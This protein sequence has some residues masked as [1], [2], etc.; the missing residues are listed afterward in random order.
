MNSASQNFRIL[1]GMLRELML[2]IARFAKRF[3]AS[4]YPEAKCP[5][6]FGFALRQENHNEKQT[7]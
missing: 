1:L 7:R 4:I 2:K 6:L 5:G 3:S